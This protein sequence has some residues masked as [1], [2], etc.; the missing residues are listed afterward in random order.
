M[1]KPIIKKHDKVTLRQIQMKTS[2]LED[3]Q[4]ALTINVNKLDDFSPQRQ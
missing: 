2:S 3:T 4:Q 1:R